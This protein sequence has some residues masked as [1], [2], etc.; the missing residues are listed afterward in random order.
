[1]RWA[2]AVDS[3]GSHTLANALAQTNYGGIVTACG[4]AQGADLPA[5]VMPFILRGITLS[6]INSVDAPLASRQR[7]WD[8]LAASFDE[9]ELAPFTRE[10]RLEDVLHH[11]GDF[12]TG[13]VRGRIVVRVEAPTV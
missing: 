1:M 4:L 5:T 2:A 12:A 10:I 13:K 9:D 11:A 8:Y 3:V 6:G 7:A